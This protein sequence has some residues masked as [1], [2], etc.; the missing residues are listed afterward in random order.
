MG[1]GALGFSDA[2]ATVEGQIFWSSWGGRGVGSQRIK[3]DSTVED[4]G[5]TGHVT[6]IRPGNVISIQSG[7]SGDGLGRLYNPDGEDGTEIPAGVLHEALDMLNPLGTAEDKS[8]NLITKGLLHE[9]E[10]LGL[11]DHAIAVFSRNGLYLDR[12]AD[13]PSMGLIPGAAMGHHM[14]GQQFHITDYTVLASENGTFFVAGTA[15]CN[16]TLPTIAAG[17]CY[18]FIM[19]GNFELAITG[20]SN[21]LTVNNLSASS[22]TYTTTAEQ[23]G[24]HLRVRSIYTATSTLKWIVEAL[25]N[26]GTNLAATIA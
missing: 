22:I 25:G 7:V 19:T 2:I 13:A 1:Q 18:E 8:F 4:S 12:H 6:T 17:L 5:N 14:L 21:I 16:F 3:M 23:I 20:S 11:D 10:L 26:N 9:N 15:D 24:A